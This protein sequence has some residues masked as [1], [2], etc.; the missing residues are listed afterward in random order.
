MSSCGFDSQF[1]KCDRFSLTSFMTVC[2]HGL[3]VSTEALSF[4][5][6]FCIHYGTIVWDNT[7]TT[8]NTLYIKTVN[9]KYAHNYVCY[10]THGRLGVQRK[11]HNRNAGL[12]LKHAGG[13][14]PV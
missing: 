13:F 11:A 3:S 6:C 9:K 14:G 5:M 8:P 1:Q 12:K 4:V 2:V 7:G 10:L